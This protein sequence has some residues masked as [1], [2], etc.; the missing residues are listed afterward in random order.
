MVETSDQH[1]EASSPAR[2]RFLVWLVRGFLS[3]WGLGI[4]WVIAAFVKSP[5][6]SRSLTEKV[7]TIGPLE[8]LPVGRAKLVHHGRE[9]IWVIRISDENLVGLSAVCT[10][11]RCV[12]TWDQAQQIL[13]CPCH[14]GSFDLNGNVLAGPPPRP[15]RQHQVETQLGQVYVHL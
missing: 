5:H 6:S 7:L 4:A 15:L 12:L 11:L 3:L 10:H 8:S 13:L 14:E 1:I 2:R 9:P